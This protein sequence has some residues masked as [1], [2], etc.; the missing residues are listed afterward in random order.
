[1]PV[2]IVEDDV[3][4]RESLEA[5][6]R[7]Q[8]IVVQSVEN[9]QEAWDVLHRPGKPPCLVLMDLM[10]PVLSGWQL[11]ERMIADEKLRLIPVIVMSATADSSTTL[12]AVA[13]MR[14]PL[15]FAAL[16]RMVKQYC[17]ADG[18]GGGT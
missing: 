3:D 13:V 12:E 17:P 7:M 16:A 15:D 6:L 2:L 1:V 9:G 11:R 8:G 14:K 10:M 18:A 4:T 5:L